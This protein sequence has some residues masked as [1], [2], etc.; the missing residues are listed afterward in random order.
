MSTNR[1][2]DLGHGISC[3]DTGMIRAGL[4]AAYIM[5]QGDKA[6]IIETGTHVCVPTILEALAELGITTEQVEYIIPTHVHLDHAGGAGGLM[7]A[8]TNATLL[9][10]PRGARHMIEPAKLKAG[11][12]AVY[13]EEIFASVYGDLIAIDE[14]RV[15]IAED[16]SEFML[17]DRQLLC[18]DSPGHARHH[19]CIHDPL[20]EGIF[21]GDTFGVSYPELSAGCE[22]RFIFPPTTPVHF[23]PPVWQQTLKRLM[24]LKPKRMYLTHFGMVE[25]LE[26]LAADLHQQIEDYANIALAQKDNA[27]PMPALLDALNKDTLARLKKVGSPMSVEEQTAIVSMDNGINAQGLAIWLSQQSAVK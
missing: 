5:Q 3:I 19:M 24:A 20:S 12:I 17:N 22:Q 4:A 26:P 1:I 8:C 11:T 23:D 14:N 18:Y 2:T 27:N 15:T 6:A 10:H 21:S 16:G 7:A 9:I 13:G 25:N